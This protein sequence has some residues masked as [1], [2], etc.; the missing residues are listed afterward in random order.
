MVRLCQTGLA[1]VCL[2]ILA[3]CSGVP[4]EAPGG[5]LSATLVTDQASARPVVQITGWSGAE[6]DALAAA[7][8]TPA[9]WPALLSL[10]VS[11]DGDVGDIA[12]AASYRVTPSGVELVPTYPL[13]PGRTYALRIDSSRPPVSRPGT[14]SVATITVPPDA[15][16]AP[17]TVSA[18]FPSAHVWPENTLRFY[19]HFSS[20]MSNTSAVGHVRLVDDSG[21]EI[22]D[23]LLDVD[24]DLWSPDY[25][26]R[27]VFFDPG[28][29]KQGI[30]ANREL[31][32]ALV[33]G[34][35]YGIVV[36]TSWKDAKGRPLAREFRHAFTAGPAVETAIDPA[37][38]TLGSVTTDTREP[39]VV[40]FPW[41]LDE[42]L[43]QRAVGVQTTAGSAVAG[44]I[45]IDHDERRWTFIPAEPW[46]STPLSLVVL[47]LL[48]DPAGNRVGE[49]FELE[50]F[51]KPADS[52]ER[53]MLAISKR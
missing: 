23:V 30:R 35:R 8:L 18:I 45:T 20:P 31:G 1:V 51:G 39:L 11:D 4:S 5:P 41:A 13:D 33:A 27:T 47:T 43:L 38:W 48:E 26:R 32:R 46:P 17:T 15:P 40:Q 12:V 36:G 42:G 16:A 21:A 44:T 7:Q 37:G 2:T 6:L 9:Q 52:V 24:V 10:H 22:A 14:T 49:P 28:R 19:L 29:V 50:M 25:T 53:V 34:R 3:A